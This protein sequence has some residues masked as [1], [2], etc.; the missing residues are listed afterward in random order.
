[1][2]RPQVDAPRD[3]TVHTYL[4]AEMASQLDQAA[5][6]EQL[7]RSAWVRRAVAIALRS[8]ATTSEAV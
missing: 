2:P 1:M 6:D 5:A 3:F 4:D 8:N 7:S